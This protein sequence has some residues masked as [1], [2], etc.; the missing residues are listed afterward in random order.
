MNCYCSLVVCEDSEGFFIDKTGKIT[1]KQN[2]KQ[3]TNRTDYKSSTYRDFDFQTDKQNDKP[4]TNKRQ[5]EPII[6]Q[7]LTEILILQTTNRTKI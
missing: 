4:P 2:D 5:T 1:D 3:T 7:A 6:N